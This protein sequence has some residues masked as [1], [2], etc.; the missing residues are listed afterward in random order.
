MMQEVSEA[1]SYSQGA[2]TCCHLKIVSGLSSLNQPIQ[3]P[4]VLHND[5]SFHNLGVAR[6]LICPVFDLV[7]TYFL[8]LELISG[9]SFLN[10]TT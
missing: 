2:V 7:I 10:Q 9:I 1:L 8:S 4:P 3:D 5:R 6:Q